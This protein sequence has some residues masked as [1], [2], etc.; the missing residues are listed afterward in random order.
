MK[1]EEI[2]LSTADPD[3]M[4]F[5]V[6]EFYRAFG[7][8]PALIPIPREKG[9]SAI[10]T[11]SPIPR[12]QT[13][14]HDYLHALEGQR[15]A[16]ACGAVSKNLC[17][18]VFFDADELARFLQ[19]NPVCRGTSTVVLPSGGVALWFKL[20]H[21]YPPTQQQGKAHWVANGSCVVV[22]GDGYM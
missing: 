16:V 3:E 13:Q 7:F 2:S 17:A 20:T 1:T 15:I 6:A 19:D 4:A 14:S 18:A 22:S 11:H 10:Q 21:S 8:L 12:D 5:T 9:D